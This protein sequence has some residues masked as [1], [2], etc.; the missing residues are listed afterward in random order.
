ML[1]PGFVNAH[2]H[3]HG[4]LAKGFFESLPLEQWGHIA[5]PMANTRSLPES[6]LRTLVGAVEALRNGIT[7][8]Q[9]FSS[10]AP[11]EDCLRKRKRTSIQAHT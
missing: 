8:V 10:F 2:Y 4:V 3:S 11:T 6:R 7:T 5:G 9:D 1:L